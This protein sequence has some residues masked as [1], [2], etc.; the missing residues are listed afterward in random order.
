MSADGLILPYEP[1]LKHKFWLRNVRVADDIPGANVLLDMMDD[2]IELKAIK[3]I[4]AGDE[5]LLWFS[6]EIL[7]FMGIP[8]L[9]PSNIQGEHLKAAK[10]VK[11]EI[12]INGLSGF[13]SIRKSSSSKTETFRQ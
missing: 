2:K 11:L 4:S 12:G 8:F 10:E 3:S 13:T 7:S 6:E 1:S 9:T 5:L